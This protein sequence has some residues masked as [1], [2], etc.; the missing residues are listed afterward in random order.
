MGGSILVAWT[1]PGVALRLPRA[2]ECVLLGRHRPLANLRGTICPMSDPPKQNIL[3]VTRLSQE[4]KYKLNQNFSS[5]W[6][7]GEISSLTR[8]SSG[9]IYLTLKDKNAQ[10]NGIIWRSEAEALKF[11]PTN[12]L[13]VVCR[14]SVDAYPQRGS[15]QLI[16]RRIQPQ[17]MG[18]LELALRQLREKLAAEGLFA[19]ERKKPLPRFPK[20]IA[21]VTS[22]SSAAVRDFLQVLNRR[23][24]NIRVTIIPVKV[25][26]PGSAEEIATG[27]KICNRLAAPIDAIVVT[28]GGGSMEDLWSF[29]S[30]LVVRAIA[31]SEIPVVSGVG[32]EIDITLSDL[33]ADV[34]AL[35]PSEAAERLVPNLDDVVGWLG[36]THQRITQLLVGR[37]RSAHQELGALASR[38]VVTQP[39][40]RIRQAAMEIDTLESRLNQ[41]AT[42][43]LKNCQ[44]QLDQ[45]TLQLESINPLSVLARGYSLTTDEAGKLV[46][47]CSSVQPGDKIISRLNKGRVIS[48]VESSSDTPIE[49]DS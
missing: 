12:G 17:G 34:R 14:G 32:H 9:H 35:T 31:A 21:V 13:K 6:V 15:Y 29:N 4:I 3:S 10:I 40:E 38:P 42:N 25:Q 36:G 33:A 26:G 37:V 46:N 30:E 45:M 16:I 7:A 23:W 24:S 20:H 22:P 47:N 49:S 48:V 18:E 27:I 19:P 2:I 39:L 28:R 44:Q 5:V 1:D 41:S 11:E 43:R 8:P